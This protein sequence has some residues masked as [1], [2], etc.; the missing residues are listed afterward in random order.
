MAKI[1]VTGATGFIG[2]HLCLVLLKK[3]YEIIGID[4]FEN[5]SPES[6]KR[7][8]KILQRQLV[9]V[10]VDLVFHEFL[11]QNRQGRQGRQGCQEL[12]LVDASLE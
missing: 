3:G 9:L 8:L 7:V 1:L 10:L 5:S 2:S 4:S 12:G 11:N 6:L